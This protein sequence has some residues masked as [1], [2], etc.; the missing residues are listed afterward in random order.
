MYR[1]FILQTRKKYIFSKVKNAASEV[2]SVNKNY[3]NIQYI[4]F[5]LSMSISLN[6][7]KHE[8]VF[9]YLNTNLHAVL[10]P[11]MLNFLY[12]LKN[13]QKNK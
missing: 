3:G 1:F 11:A 10:A 7:A 5:T 9:P 6:E 13:N 4:N 12:L 8:N 2:K